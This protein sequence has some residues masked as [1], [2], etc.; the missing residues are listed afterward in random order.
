MEQ[1]SD[2]LAAD[3]ED[4]WRGQWFGGIVA[5]SAIVGAVVNTVL[6]GPWQAS[7][8]L[9]GVPILSAVQAFIRG[10]ESRSE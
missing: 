1:E 9:V 6:G 4:T 2:G 5:F 8:A 10:R 7:V 3:I